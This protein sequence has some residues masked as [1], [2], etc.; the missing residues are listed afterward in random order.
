M[1]WIYLTD[2]QPEEGVPV[3]LGTIAEVSEGYL[4]A[5]GRF[6]YA[7]GTRIRGVIAWMPLPAPPEE[8]A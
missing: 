2:R 7:D 1:T 4:T 5:Y 6:C 3:L 8:K